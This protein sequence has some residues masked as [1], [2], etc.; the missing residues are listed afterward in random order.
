MK[1]FLVVLNQDK[2]LEYLINQLKKDHGVLIAHDQ[3]EFEKLIK[4]AQ[5]THLL[6]PI[7]GVDN[8]LTIRGGNTQLT[9]EILGHLR[10]KTILTG[11][12]HE[13]LQLACQQFEVALETYMTDDFAIDNNYI[14]CEGIIEGLVKLSEK[15]IYQSNILILGYGRLGQILAKVLTPFKV[16]LWIAARDEKDLTKIKIE[17][18]Q[19]LPL[20][21]IGKAL[22]EVDFVITTIPKE[23]MNHEV[24]E[25]LIDKDLLII[26]V[27]SHPYSFDHDYAKELGLNVHLLA[28][29]PGRIAPKSSGE[30]LATYISLL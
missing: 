18:N 10:G 9:E 22:D 8:N 3:E 17:G 16:K 2:R 11:L 27:S 29:I 12:M 5:Y 13:S 15:A 19:A 26:D 21:Q 6:L 4:E 14:T 23:V 7:T 30:L 28:K 1:E 25:S 20:N 24:L